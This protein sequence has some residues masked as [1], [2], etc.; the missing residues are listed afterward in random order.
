MPESKPNDLAFARFGTANGPPGQKSVIEP[1]LRFP[2]IG[3]LSP[4]NLFP[5][6]ASPMVLMVI[7]LVIWP[8]GGVVAQVDRSEFD[9]TLRQWKSVYLKLIE[10]YGEINTCEESEFDALKKQ[11]LELKAQGDQLKLEAIE[12]AAAAYKSSDENIEDIKRFIAPLP[13]KLFDEYQY[14]IA[15]HVNEALLRHDPLNSEF[16]FDGIKAAFF[17][18]DFELCARL[19]EQWKTQFGGP[20]QQLQSIVDVLGDYRSAW[21]AQQKRLSELDSGAPRPRLELETAK[22]TIVVELDE[23]QFPIVVNNLVNNVTER[24]LYRGFQFF[25]VLEHQ[26]VRSGC[27]LN[28]G[29]TTLNLAMLKP[30]TMNYPQRHFRGT[31]TL[32]VNAS[33]GGATTQFSICRIPMPDFNG[34]YLPIGRVVSGME[35]VDNLA[36]THELDEKM[37]IAPIEGAVPDNIINARITNKRDHDYTF[38]DE[39]Q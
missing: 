6:F 24:S 22:G 35:I 23:D 30:E 39:I 12:K 5:I 9:E 36:N 11:I 28:N 29:T 31:F 37:A 4:R 8:S 15:A 13:I 20:P 10:C 1:G 19:L 34:R 38:R 27:P 3:R 25:E 16:M 18:N 32:L 2:Q 14:E 21:Q 7:C 33:N 26:L 17:A